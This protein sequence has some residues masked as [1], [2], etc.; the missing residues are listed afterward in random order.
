[1]NQNVNNGNSEEEADF[2]KALEEKKLFLKSQYLERSRMENG[3]WYIPTISL[4]GQNLHNS[5]WSTFK[6][7][8]ISCS[9][10]E[11]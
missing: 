9:Q 10:Y 8:N 3:S 11:S 5:S 1:M 2:R 4:I 7:H 6:S